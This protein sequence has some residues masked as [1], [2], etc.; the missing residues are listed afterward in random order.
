[1]KILRLFLPVILLGTA[2]FS[3][4]EGKDDDEEEP[5]A[6]F[7]HPVCPIPLTIVEKTTSNLRLYRNGQYIE[8][9]RRK[10]YGRVTLYKTSVT[11]TYYILEDVIREAVQRGMRVDRSVNINLPASAFPGEWALEND[12]APRFRPLPSLPADLPSAGTVWKEFITLALYPERAGEAVILPTEIRYRYEGTGMFYGTSVHRV[13]GF[14][15]LDQTVPGDRIVKQVKGEHVLNIAFSSDTRLPLF[16]KDQIEE[17]FFLKSGETAGCKGFV[18]HWFDF[19]GLEGPGAIEELAKELEK[20]I[21]VIETDE[22]PGLRIKDLRFEPD[23]AVLL[24]GEETRLDRIGEILQKN[25]DG[26]VLILGHTAS[27][28]YPEGE[29]NLSVERAKKVAEILIANGVDAEKILYEGRG[30][31]E[32]IADNDTEAGRARNRRVEIIL[33]DR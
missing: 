22:G 5:V 13:T 14:I 20:G 29:M 33:I 24:P 16:I 17:T 2:I 11:G 26:A 10:E 28:G 25:G 30:S 32:P 3:F 7:N 9:V 12:P 27:I 8:H 6:F 1:V 15:S 31:T 4:G 23:K 21:E 18:N 19:P